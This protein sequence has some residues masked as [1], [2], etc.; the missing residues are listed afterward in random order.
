MRHE[1]SSVCNLLDLLG[2]RLPHKLL[3]SLR[4][5]AFSG[6]EKA[7][8]IQV[9]ACTNHRLKRMHAQTNERIHK[10]PNTFF[11]Y[12]L[13][14]FHPRHHT[15]PLLENKASIMT[16]LKKDKGTWIHLR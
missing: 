2:R 14:A 8:V 4:S 5:W 15:E 1:S 7:N 16:G 12:R 13:S 9:Y 6:L 3:C 11:S 10:P